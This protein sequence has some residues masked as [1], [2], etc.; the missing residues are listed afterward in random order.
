[1]PNLFTFDSMEP[2]KWSYDLCK[3]G[4]LH[5]KCLVED[6][7][8]PASDF[9]TGTDLCQQ[10]WLKKEAILALDPKQV[11]DDGKEWVFVIDPSKSKPYGEGA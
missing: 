4:P 3:M 2:A 1:M 11:E 7:Y 5:Q 8:T 10:P 6:E 9:F